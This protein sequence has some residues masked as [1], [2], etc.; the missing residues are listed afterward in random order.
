MS[1]QKKRN[2][3]RRLDE[4]AAKLKIKE[5]NR[6]EIQTTRRRKKMI[7]NT[8]ALED[9][10]KC[11]KSMG[12]RKYPVRRARVLEILNYYNSVDDYPLNEMEELVYADILEILPPVI[13]RFA[14]DREIL[15]GVMRVL[16]ATLRLGEWIA[17]LRLRARGLFPVLFELLRSNIIT[18]ASRTQKCPS[19][20]DSITVVWGG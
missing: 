20:R 4:P 14:G 2:L 3:S 8:L 5:V 19:V 15:L 1:M 6:K 17:G 12:T 7:R 13:T 10:K 11:N 18:Y 9:L 16:K